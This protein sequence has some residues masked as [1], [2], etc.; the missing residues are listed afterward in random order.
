[1]SSLRCRSFAK[2]N[3]HLEVLGR[4]ADGYHELST[5]FQSVELHDVLEVELTTQGYAVEVVEGEAPEDR[6]NLAVRAASALQA[7]FA[8]D[9]GARIRLWKG[10]PLGS[11]LGGGSSNAATTLWALDRLLGGP[12][13]AAELLGI[14][15]EL[16]ADVPYFLHGGTAWGTGR[17]DHIQPLSDL[18]EQEVWLVT[19]PVA[20]STADVFAR[21]DAPYGNHL[22]PRETPSS[23]MRLVEAG[24]RASADRLEAHNDLEE[25][26]LSHY[27]E[28]REAR[29][30]LIE[31]GGAP[32][33]LS[34]SGATLYA[35][36]R[37]PVD[38]GALRRR[39]PAG[40]RIVC[41]RTLSRQSYL[42]SRIIDPLEGLPHMVRRDPAG[43]T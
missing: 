17:G 16:G 20:V 29:A 13:S 35:F 2:I 6:T 22:T 43:A 15:A 7:R 41:S 26:V 1:M 42:A 5:L 10:I 30:V 11:G 18:A 27:P 37:A 32:V 25:G 33:R 12:A 39:L 4:R 36:F 21:L 24:T 3:L 19:P 34:G 23:I 38:I 28:I 8:P 40:S 31:A 9:R 14:A